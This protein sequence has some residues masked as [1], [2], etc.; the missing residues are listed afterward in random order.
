VVE[1]VSIIDESTIPS[2]R[3]AEPYTRVRFLMHRKA[4][5]S[6]NMKKKL[7]FLSIIINY[8][9]IIKCNSVKGDTTWSKLTRRVHVEFNED[10]I[11]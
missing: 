9:S 2:M 10:A 6:I 8:L 11:F 3:H 5:I 4:L 1:P 7:T